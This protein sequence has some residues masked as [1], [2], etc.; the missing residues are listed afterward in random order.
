MPANT[1]ASSSSAVS[2]VREGE[3]VSV[4]E[5]SALAGLAHRLLAASYKLSR[6]PITATCYVDAP[7]SCS[8]RSANALRSHSRARRAALLQVGGLVEMGGKGASAS[9]VAMRR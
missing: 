2:G 8:S 1:K 6:L 3:S 9:M 5:G 7:A 4:G